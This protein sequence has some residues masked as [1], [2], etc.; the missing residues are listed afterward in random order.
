MSQFVNGRTEDSLDIA[1]KLLNYLPSGPGLAT[2]VHVGNPRAG[3]EV[4]HGLP[5]CSVVGRCAGTLHRDARYGARIRLGGMTFHPL[6]F[7]K[8]RLT[9]TR[10]RH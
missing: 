10:R 2:L 7:V 1:I 5:D 8:L 3:E 6:V 9:L 4:N